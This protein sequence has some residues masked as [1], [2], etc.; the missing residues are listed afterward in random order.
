MSR[1]GSF[2]NDVEGL[3]LRCGSFG[4]SIVS[5]LTIAGFE[6][7]SEENNPANDAVDGT[8]ERAISGQAVKCSSSF[9]C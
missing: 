1:S 3:C 5:S 2:T 8:S 9:G 7:P 4:L 6:E